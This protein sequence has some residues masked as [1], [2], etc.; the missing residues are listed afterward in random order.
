[1]LEHFCE[2]TPGSLIEEKE[3]SLTWHYRLA[4]PEYGHWL[5][6]ELAS[7]LD[8][9]LAETDLR[10]SRGHRNVEVRPTWA[11]KGNVVRHIVAQAGD[12][13]FRLA[14][15]DDRTD[16]DMF[17]ALEAEDWTVRVGASATRARFTVADYRAVRALLERLASAD[18][19]L[20]A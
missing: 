13:P 14:A 8:G 12:A 5:A 11:N 9:M 19:A 7:M 18:A 20:T 15:G 6:N 2:R 1:V 17:A 10:P 3:L 16:E 4:E